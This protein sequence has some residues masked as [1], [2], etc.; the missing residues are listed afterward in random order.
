M[1]VLSIGNFDG[2]HEGH[3]AL[4]ARAR[5]VADAE[6]S[7]GQ[8]T[9]VTFDPLPHALLLPG[10]SPALIQTL[11]GRV[12]ALRAAGADNVVVLAVD[13]AFLNVAADVFLADLLAKIGE[14]EQVG[15]IVEGTDFCFG[16]GR[17]G[18][19]ET[20]MEHGR[21]AGFAVELLPTQRILLS[22]GEEVEA[23]SSTLRELL[24]AGRVEDA[25]KVLGRPVEV[26]GRVV[27]GDARGRD[28]GFPTANLDVGECLLPGEGVYA[29]M[30]YLPDGTQW[31]AAVSIGTKPTFTPTASVLEAHL[32]GWKGEIGEYDWVMK[33][34]LACRLRGQERFDGIEPLKAKMEEDCAAV[35]ARSGS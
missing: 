6:T 25:A 20:L 18:T 2:V 3:R 32:I 15:A 26:C 1:H 21:K 31:P 35:L 12:E 4:L 7:G 19:I 23:R 14:Q 30:A 9:A 16:K 33:V 22:G 27:K 28:L 17:A 10:K 8:V 5:K 11:E 24:Q 13:Q 34:E 29:G